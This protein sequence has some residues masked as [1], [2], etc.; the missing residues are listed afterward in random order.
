MRLGGRSHVLGFLLCPVL[1]PSLLRLGA[2][3]PHA[4]AAPAERKD[5]PPCDAPSQESELPLWVLVFGCFGESVCPCS[6]N[7][8]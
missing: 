6:F 5:Q 8:I 3:M 7:V 4:A 2:K 1:G